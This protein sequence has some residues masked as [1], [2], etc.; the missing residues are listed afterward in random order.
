MTT[1]MAA[2][3]IAVAPG[4]WVAD[5]ARAIGGTPRASTS[6]MVV[7]ARVGGLRATQ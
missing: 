2:V 4:K 6:E 5:A 1:A 3:A 7:A